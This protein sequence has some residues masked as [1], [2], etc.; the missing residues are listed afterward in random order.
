MSDS[1]DGSTYVPLLSEKHSGIPEGLLE[2]AQWA[3]AHAASVTTK[4]P[5]TTRRRALAYPPGVEEKVFDEAVDALR[6][7]LGADHVVLNDQPL[8]DGW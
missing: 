5:N 6:G 8:V 1:K 2:K 3:K 7:E 4:P